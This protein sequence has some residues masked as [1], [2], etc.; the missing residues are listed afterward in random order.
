[1]CFN[2]KGIGRFDLIARN[3]LYLTLFYIA[4]TVYMPFGLIL[5]VILSSALIFKAPFSNLINYKL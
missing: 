2:V 4:M 5:A 3:A 1:M